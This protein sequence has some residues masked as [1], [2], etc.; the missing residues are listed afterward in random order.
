MSA[1]PWYCETMCEHVPRNSWEAYYAKTRVRGPRPL[2]KKAIPYLVRRDKALDLGAGVLNDTSYLLRKGFKHVTAVDKEAVPDVARAFPRKRF[3]HIRSSFETFGFP[4]NAFDIVTAQYSLP[5]I[6]PVDFEAVFTKVKRSLV[7]G[8]IF[9]GQLF[10]DR[11]EWNIPPQS[12]TFLTRQAVD[13]LLADMRIL[14]LAEEERDSPTVTS[15]QLKHWHV[16]HIIS[17]KG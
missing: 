15:E 16:F 11:D 4:E 9:T 5:F 13:R 12:M 17:K 7:V 10:G 8:G 14:E 2:L 3:I 6:Q 1:N